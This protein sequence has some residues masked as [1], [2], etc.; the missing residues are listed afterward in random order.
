[1][2]TC[3]AL[4]LLC[5]FIFL[6]AC[7][8]GDDDHG[9][10]ILTNTNF[11]YEADLHKIYLDSTIVQVSAT[12]DSLQGIIDNNQGDEQTQMLLDE[13]RQQRSE[14]KSERES[15]IDPS[16]YALKIIG[17]IPP[18]PPC[19]CIIPTFSYLVVPPDGLARKMTIF[20]LEGN[21]IGASSG[22][23]I[24]ISQNGGAAA[25]QEVIF[26]QPN[27]SGA[28]K[29]AVD[30]ESKIYESFYTLNN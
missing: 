30:T 19:F 26:D 16:Q 12:I 22:V 24:P 4:L 7:N 14:L 18:L 21:V 27:F 9:Q 3:N 11:V 5:S 17:P 8:K 25:Y 6:S 29:I 15:I 2:K 10:V 1:M 28:I 20:D 23:S 13:K